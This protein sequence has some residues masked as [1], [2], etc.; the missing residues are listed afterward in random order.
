ML[1]VRLQRVGRKNDPSF[2]VVVT[3]S[4]R[5]PKSGNYIENLGSYNPRAKSLNLNGERI[6]HWIAN[7]AQVSDTVHNLLVKEKVIEGKKIN[8]LPKKSP[9]VK[10][11]PKKEDTGDTKQETG[12]APA[13]EVSAEDESEVE[14]D[15]APDEKGN[16]ET[17]KDEEST[18]KST[19]PKVE[20]YSSEDQPD[21]SGV[22]A[23]E[24]K[25]SISPEAETDVQK[26][27]EESQPED[28]TEEKEK[29]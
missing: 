24:G 11:D 19:N 14:S 5:G 21:T 13:Q 20:E 7:G 17:I 18:K 4:R 9:V 23:D 12:N 10:E 6:K 25:A 29:A 22:E 16:A 3:D 27:K 1:K 2:R 28:I 26:T 15:V 8:V